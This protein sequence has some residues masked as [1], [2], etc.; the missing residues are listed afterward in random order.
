MKTLLNSWNM[1]YC[2]FELTFHWTVHEDGIWLAR[3]WCSQTHTHTRTHSGIPV[4]TPR[5]N[6]E[7]LQSFILCFFSWIFLSKPAEP[8]SKL[9]SSHQAC[10]VFAQITQWPPAIKEVL[11][12]R[13]RKA[14]IQLYSCPSSNLKQ[15]PLLGNWKQPDILTSFPIGFHIIKSS[16][17]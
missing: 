13:Q 14:S 10:S 5:H 12:F 7:L 11:M 6:Q 4:C 8:G 16:Y 17:V 9:K 1:I 3:L 15:N 2:I